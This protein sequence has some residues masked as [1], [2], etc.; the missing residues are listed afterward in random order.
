MKRFGD[1]IEER[2]D[3]LL[4]RFDA[5]LYF[6][7]KNYFKKHLLKAINAKGD[8]LKG[9]ILNAEAINYID[10][11]ASIMLISVINELHDRNLKF[12]IAGAI[13]PTRDIIFNSGIIKVLGKE[14]LFVRT[15]EAVACF[16]KTGEVSDFRQKIAHQTKIR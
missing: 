10:S 14:F 16:D 5:Q 8:A 2:D 1:E 11:S 12:Y 7:N 3:L 13:G 4:L 6:G 9:V 15:E